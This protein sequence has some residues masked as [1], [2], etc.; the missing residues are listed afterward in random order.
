VEA[1]LD[2]YIPGQLVDFT[3][4][5]GKEVVFVDINRRNAIEGGAECRDVLVSLAVAELMIS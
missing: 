4:Q 3:T 1:L 2:P 5:C